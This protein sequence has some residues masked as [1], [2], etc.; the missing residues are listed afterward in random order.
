MLDAVHVLLHS[1][2]DRERAQRLASL[3]ATQ[4]AITGHG[5]N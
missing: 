2:A 3:E 1:K 5:L 4:I